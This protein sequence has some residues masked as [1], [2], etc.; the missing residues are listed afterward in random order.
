MCE[1]QYKVALVGTAYMGGLLIGS[2]LS[3]YPSDKFG[4]KV[5]LFVFIVFAGVA[6]F[7]GAFLHEYW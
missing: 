7:V 5:M 6:N 4:R 3:S 2:F 1:D